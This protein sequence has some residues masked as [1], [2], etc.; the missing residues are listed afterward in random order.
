M[1]CKNLIRI[2]FILVRGTSYDAPRTP[3]FDYIKKST[4]ESRFGK[5]EM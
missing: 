2:R 3:K 5:H 1:T 4:Y